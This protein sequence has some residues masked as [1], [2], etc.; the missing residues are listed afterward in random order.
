[1]PRRCEDRRPDPWSV[2][3]RTHDSLI[4]G[5]LLGGSANGR[6]QHTPPIRGSDSDVRLNRALRMLADGLRQLNA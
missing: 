1:M 6:R 2:V 3:N 5:G 4:K